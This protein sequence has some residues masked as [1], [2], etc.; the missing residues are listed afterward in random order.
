MYAATAALK[1]GELDQA[2]ALLA[3]VLTFARRAA[4]LMAPRPGR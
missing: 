3:P 1:R 2:T 4:D